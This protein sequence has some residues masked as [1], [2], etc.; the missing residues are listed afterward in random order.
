MMKV[1]SNKCWCPINTETKE[2][3]KPITPNELQLNQL[4]VIKKWDG[5]NI[6]DGHIVIA[7]YEDGDD[8]D[9]YTLMLQSLTDTKTNWSNLE[10]LN[11]INKYQLELLPPGTIVTLFQPE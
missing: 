4:A 9:G 5:T 2:T 1:N 3:Q 8:E 6:F 10:Y 7:V 11:D